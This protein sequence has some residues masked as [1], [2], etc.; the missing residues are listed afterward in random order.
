MKADPA[1][2]R[3]RVVAPP[4]DWPVLHVLAMAHPQIEGHEQE[5]SQAR[6]RTRQL[7]MQHAGPEIAGPFLTAE[8]SASGAGRAS[9]SHEDGFSLLA[10]CDRG[11]VGID[12][13]GPRGLA[14]ASPEELERITRLYLG[15]D[16]PPTAVSTNSAQANRQ[17][18]A[19]AW[20]C[21]EAKLKC[22]GLA[23]DEYTSALQI[24]LADCRTAR[25]ALPPSVAR[26]AGASEAWIA[27]RGGPESQCSS[28]FSAGGGMLGQ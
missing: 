3:C 12:V 25:V 5:R 14:A 9:I 7:L 6:Q 19:M 27:W 2:W 8:A 13:V 20:A 21:H 26:A 10:W 16:P 24:Q 11:C 23:L 28:A 15:A 18:F 22:L 17:C 1:V 4:P